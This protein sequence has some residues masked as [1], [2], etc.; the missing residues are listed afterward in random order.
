MLFEDGVKK[1]KD[2]SR[3]SGGSKAEVVGVKDLLIEKL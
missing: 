1:K 2:Y 3:R